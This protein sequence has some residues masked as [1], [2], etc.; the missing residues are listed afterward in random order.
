MKLAILLLLISL[1]VLSQ[2]SSIDVER[3]LTFPTTQALKHWAEKEY[4]GGGFVDLVTNDGIE[5]AIARRSFTSGIPTCALS[6]F[7]KSEE[8]WEEA[9]KLRTY[10]GRWFD[11]TQ[12]GDMVFIRDDK[13]KAEV[14]RFSIAQLSLQP[15]ETK[16]K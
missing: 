8:G 6:V 10:R 1:P 16:R 13:S 3:K 14:L 7:V 11:F 4:F 2:T 12:D 15:F 9:L 5:V